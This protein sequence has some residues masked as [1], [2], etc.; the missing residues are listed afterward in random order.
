MA[1]SFVVRK[2]RNRKPLSEPFRSNG[3]TVFEKHDRVKILFSSAQSGYFYLLNEESGK[4]GDLANLRILFPEENA[5]AQLTADE[6]VTIPPP[7]ANP[8]E[9]WIEFYEEAAAEKIW[10]VWSERRID[11]LEVVKKWSNRRHEGEIKDPVQN[12]EV[13]AFLNSHRHTDSRVKKREEGTRTMLSADSD[14]I[15]YALN[16]TRVS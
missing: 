14:I 16:L 13:R 1:Y 15:V 10:M 2:Y 12:Q 4:A 11:V 8:E 9:D 6:T 7:S 5:T 3:E